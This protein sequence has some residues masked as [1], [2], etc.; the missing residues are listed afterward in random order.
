MK[1][2]D[3]TANAPASLIEFVEKKYTEVDVDEERRKSRAIVVAQERQRREEENL[4]NGLKYARKIWRWVQ[5]MQQSDLGKKMMRLSHVPT[6]YRLVYFWD[7]Y[8][9][10][11][12]NWISLAFSEDGLIRPL[13]TRMFTYTKFNSADE[14][15]KDIP[16]DILK[17]VCQAID[18]GSVWQRIEKGFK[19]KG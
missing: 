3:I 17:E 10:G 14:L 9:T 4:Q 11:T 19:Q 2:K 1:K 6:A 8:E 13:G 15:A 7:G 5:N 16:T 12:T 18:C